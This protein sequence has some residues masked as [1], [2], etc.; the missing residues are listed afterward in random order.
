MIKKAS[1]CTINQYIKCLFDKN[2]SA[3]GEGTEQELL[4]AF[5]NIETE[6]IDLSGQ[7]ESGEYE[8]IRN[9]MTI[10]SRIEMV[11][12]LMYIHDTCL[13]E[14]GRPFLPAITDLKKFGYELIW[15]NDIE[16]FRKQLE[17]IQI[18]E[19]RY[20]IQLE[21]YKT[22]LKKPEENIIKTERNRPEFIRMLINLQKQGY[23]IDRDVTTI[24]DLAII[25]SELR[26][27][28]IANELN[29]S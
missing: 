22:K 18:S 26:E 28:M 14:F 21:D 24:E 20:L 8:I 17:G 9:I 4:D 3:L 6:Y 19:Q 25:V 1:E 27:Q 12:I 15:N 7:F 13:T 16:D 11:N 29:P 2:Y 5:Q 23:K 10:S